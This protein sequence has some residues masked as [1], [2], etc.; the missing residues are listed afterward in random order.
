MKPE[1]GPFHRPSRSR[2][3][4]PRSFKE[5]TPTK[6]FNPRSFFYELVWKARLT[7]RKGHLAALAAL[8]SLPE[9]LRRRIVWLVVGAGDEKDYLEDVP[10][11]ISPKLKVHFVKTADQVLRIALEKNPAKSGD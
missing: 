7:R 11:E 5:L 8:A 2:Q 6:A 10:D 9:R 1:P 4:L 3:R